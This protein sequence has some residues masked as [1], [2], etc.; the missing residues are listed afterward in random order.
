MKERAR[1]TFLLR[2]AASLELV[3]PKRTVNLIE[4]DKILIFTPS[5]LVEGGF[6]DFSTGNSIQ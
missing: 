2:L 4:S 5:R 1:L 3:F 6:Q